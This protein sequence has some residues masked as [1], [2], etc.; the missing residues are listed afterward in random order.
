M[1]GT[2]SKLV[3]VILLICICSCRNSVTRQ[4]S[5]NFP[6]DDS[7]PAGEA[8]KLSE[9]AIAD[10]VQNIASP[11]EIAAIL[12]ALNVPFSAE[13]LAPTQGADRLTTNF[14]KAVMLGIYG[15]D[16]GYLNMYEKTGN[17]VDVLSTI[18]RLADGLRV[19]Q[20]FDF[21]TL[22]RLSVNKSDLDSLLF[23]SVNSYNQ[24]DQYLRQNGR[25]SIS[26]LMIAGVWI[27]GQY[28]ATQV[29]TDHQDK[30]LRDRIGEQKIILGDLL[31]LLRPYRESNAEYATL[32]NMMEQI[33]ASYRDVRIT[34]RLGEPETLEQDGRLVMIQH[35]ESIVEM[36]DEQLMTIAQ[37]SGDVR[38]KLISGKL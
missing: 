16:L 35:E 25:G 26:A 1:T 15:A 24:I 7:V 21:E 36:T 6:V 29:V 30:V 20:Y 12:Q 38:N 28:L 19:G 8:E 2:I 14:Q 31:M 37:L 34:Y 32:Y 23:M 11:V 9:E 17:S 4:G 27:E 33:S 10:I 18:K 22:K 3:A 5:L 13:Y